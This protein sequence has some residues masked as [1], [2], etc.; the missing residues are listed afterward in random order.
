MWGGALSSFGAF[1]QGNYRTIGSILR[2]LQEN[3]P[4]GMCEVSAVPEMPRRA[5]L[6][7]K[8]TCCW[9]TG[10]AKYFAQ[11][12]RSCIFHDEHGRC[13]LG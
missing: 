6:L 11:A 2:T 7:T 13:R 4:S 5:M 3:N 12:D 1:T 8:A 9:L 10:V